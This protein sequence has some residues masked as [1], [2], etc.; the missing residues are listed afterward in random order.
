MA[1]EL[2]DLLAKKFVDSTQNRPVYIGWG[3][4]ALDYSADDADSFLRHGDYSAPTLEGALIEEGHMQEVALGDACLEWL[5][6]ASD[7]EDVVAL[8]NESGVDVDLDRESLACGIAERVREDYFEDVNFDER[9]FFK[10]AEDG[11]LTY[12][13]LLTPGDPGYVHVGE[14]ELEDAEE[15][16]ELANGSVG[17]S[18]EELLQAMREV[19]DDFYSLWCVVSMP[20]RA[21][22]DAFHGSKTIDVSSPTIYVGNYGMGAY[23][24]FKMSGSLKVRLDDLFPY[25]PYLNEYEASEVE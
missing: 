14:P 3:V 9:E 18:S 16:L 15:L 2:I 6:E 5:Q 17:V 7:D 10:S 19:P 25:F 24:D 12:G 13:V 20:Q 4:G 22:L 21:L 11:I 8:I 23:F 1:S